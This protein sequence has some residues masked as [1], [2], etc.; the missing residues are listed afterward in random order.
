[1]KYIGPEYKIK[2][3]HIIREMLSLVMNHLPYHVSFQRSRCGPFIFL[4]DLNPSAILRAT[5]EQAQF[6][7]VCV[8]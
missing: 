2:I 3:V 1:M 4:S 7:M 5:R 6:G 8:V